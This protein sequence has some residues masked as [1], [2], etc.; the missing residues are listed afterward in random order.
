M[1]HMEQ[2]KERFNHASPYAS[3]E[4]EKPGAS[5]G[6]NPEEV[7][8]PIHRKGRRGIAETGSGVNP[9]EG[10]KGGG[11]T[12]KRPIDATNPTAQTIK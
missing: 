2:L 12:Q 7:G 3:K 9:K 6:Q 5:L 8:F 1:F 11:E 10:P 4:S